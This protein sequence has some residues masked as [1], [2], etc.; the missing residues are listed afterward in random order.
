MTASSGGV[1]PCR[2]A[3]VPI[4]SPALRREGG[5]GSRGG[6]QWLISPLYVS[7]SRKRLCLRNWSWDRAGGSFIR[8]DPRGT[9]VPTKTCQTGNQSTTT[10]TPSELMPSPHQ[11]RHLPTCDLRASSYLESWFGQANQHEQGR[12]IPLVQPQDKPDFLAPSF[13]AVALQTGAYGPAPDPAS[14]TRFRG[15]TGRAATL[16]NLSTCRVLISAGRR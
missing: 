5:Y 14:R 12:A 11:R 3:I 15:L 13:P 7:R 9:G 16:T 1:I 6:K 8:L 10:R 4:S 2:R